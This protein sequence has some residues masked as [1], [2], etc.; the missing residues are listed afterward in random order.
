MEQL[1]QI[2]KHLFLLLNGLHT[3]KLDLIMFY[4]TKPLFWTPVFL[5]LIYGIFQFKKSS[6][7]RAALFI[8]FLLVIF[9]SDRVSVLAFKEVFL[10][11][12]PCHNFDLLP[13]THIVKQHCGGLYGF[14]SSHASNFMGMATYAII[15]LKPSKTISFL[16]FI[17][18]SFVCYTRVYLGVH[19][20]LDILCGSLLGISIGFMVAKNVLHYFIQSEKFN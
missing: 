10:R 2:D 6:F 3:D 7:N 14:L 18:A 5:Y 4:A 8:G 17:W 11:Y 1:E 15:A 16:L 20:P 12:R 13:I 9:L 19:Y